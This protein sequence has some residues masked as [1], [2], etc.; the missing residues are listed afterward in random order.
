MLKRYPLAMPMRVTSFF[1]CCLMLSVALLATH[2]FAQIH[3]SP[4]GNDTNPGT[5]AQPVRTLE[6]AVALARGQEASATKDVTIELVGGSYRLAR[7]LA[8]TADDSGRNGHNLIFTAQVGAHPIISGALQIRGWKKVDG[9]KNIWAAPVP[10]TVTASRQLYV[11]GV[12]ATRTRGRLPL[13]VTM[14]VTG[15]TAAGATMAAWKQPAELEF[16][17]TGG[18]ALW[19]ESSVGLG[20]WTEPRCPVASIDGTTIT[21]AQPCWNNST[22]RVMLPPGPFKRTANLVGPASVGKAPTYVENA[23]ELLGTPG[24]FYL[25]HGASKIYYV[26]RPGEDLAKSD[27]ELPVLENLITASGTAANPVHN[28]VFSGLQFSYATWL[29]PNGPDGFSEIQAGYQ[30]TGPEGYSKQALC[31]LVPGGTCPYGA[32]TKEPANIELHFAH[33]IQFVRDA[34]VHLG[35]AGLDLGDGAQNDV[36]EGSVFTDISGNGLELAGVA[37]PLAPDAEFA[38][39]NRIDNNLFEDV[40]AE[41]RGGIGIVIGYARHTLVTH[42]QIDHVPYAAMS[43]GWGGWPDKIQLAGQA[44]RSMGNIISNNLAH[45]L[46]LVLSDGGGIYTQGRTGETLADGEQVNGNVIYD[47]YSSG[48]AIY[49]DNGSSMITVNGNVM[50]HTDHDNWGSRHRDWYDGHDG[51][52]YDPLLIENNYWQQGDADS[53]KESVTEQDNHLINSLNEV[54]ADLLRNAGLQTAF[55]DITGERFAKA[56]PPEPPSRVA[57]WA[58][59]GMAYVTWSPSIDQGGSPVESYT[60]RSSAGAEAHISAEDFRKH[61]Y[62]KVTGLT[63]GRPLTFMVTAASRIGASV[64]SMPSRRVTPQERAIESPAAPQNVSVHVGKGV[65]S[66]HFQLPQAAPSGDGAPVLAYAVTVN[67]SGRRVMFTGRNIVV[68][69]G[70][71]ST[72]NVVDG[73][74]SGASYSFSVAAVNASGEGTPTVVGPVTIP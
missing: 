5:Q 36:V 55:L 25:D 38:S 51:K 4:A 11:D 14:T 48:H 67:P 71:H 70:A 50:F 44:N 72:F 33:N 40:G 35:A 31:T 39:D 65:A 20:S 1:P 2:C 12:R 21:M 49:T 45:D 66:I 17:Y 22:L 73:L 9:A 6:R 46:M 52:D 18:N 13:D 24:Q 16:V 23:Y 69:E 68:L 64:V 29:A 59:N 19:S 57:V 54:P 42:N 53:S 34:F 32:W 27:V 43:I 61:A 62:V 10:S 74:T 7:P 28:I 3:V 58:G 41:F 47:Q 56:A 26:P 30:V 15:Y 60:V 8:L 37:Q 63:N